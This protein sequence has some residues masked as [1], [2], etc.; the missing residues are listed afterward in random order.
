MDY[1]DWVNVK[2]HLETDEQGWLATPEVHDL[3][4]KPINKLL[5]TAKIRDMIEVGCASGH[6]ASRIDGIEYIGLDKNPTF[7]DMSRRRNPTKKFYQ[8]D[9]RNL[10]GKWSADLVVCFAVLKHFHLTEWRSIFANVLACGQK[11]A[12]VE[13]PDPLQ[14]QDLDGNHIGVDR[15]VED[16]CYDFPHVWVRKEEIIE[17][18]HH[19][20]WE[21]IDLQ[22]TGRKELV[23]IFKKRN[24]K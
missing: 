5:E 1:C 20:D 13:I 18:A 9:I 7:L 12:I 19:L 6:L 21:L 16:V 2:D 4:V 10:P 17:L 15:T 11:Y 14:R 24:G 8:E 22:D 23:Y 3:Q